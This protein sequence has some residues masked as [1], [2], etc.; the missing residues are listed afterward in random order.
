MIFDRLLG[1]TLKKTGKLFLLFKK[2]STFVSE[3]STVL[4]S[5]Y[6]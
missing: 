3:S 2:N 4:Y 1:I 6:C 5:Y